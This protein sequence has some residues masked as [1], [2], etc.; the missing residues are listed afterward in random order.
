MEIMKCFVLA[1]TKK[2][3]TWATRVFEEWVLERNVSAKEQCPV[4]LVQKPDP[5][6]LNVWLCRFVAEVR[7]KD[8]SPYPPCSIHLILPGLQ[9]TVLRSLS[10][11]TKM[12]DQ[13]YSTYH[14]IRR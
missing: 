7:K 8:G 2:R 6:L 3:T 13:S 5:K 9:R 1:N 12:F 14:D 4:D 11:C 10:K